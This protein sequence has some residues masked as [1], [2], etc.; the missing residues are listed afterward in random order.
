VV[1]GL[2]AVES[3]TEDFTTLCLEWEGKQ[4]P[5][6]GIEGMTEQEITC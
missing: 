4:V 3:N 5:K 1:D 6:G 2:N